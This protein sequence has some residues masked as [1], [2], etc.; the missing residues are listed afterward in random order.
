MIDEF[1]VL[2]NVSKRFV[3]VR[4]LDSVNVAIKRSEI[5]CLVGENGSGKSTLVKIISG[6][7]QPDEGEMIVRGEAVTFTHTIDSIRLGIEVIYQDMSLFPNLTVAENIVLSHRIERG[8]RIFRWN[9]VKEIAREA[10]EK[11]HVS[12][13]LDEVVGR[14]PV[15]SQQLVAICRALTSGVQLLVMDEATTALTKKEIDRLLSVIEDLRGKGL[16]VV[17]VSHKLNE[18]LQIADLVTILRDGRSVGTYVN[19]DLTDDK[20]TFLMTGRKLDKA[21]L[22]AKVQTS[23]A[24]LEATALTKSGQ[25]RN[26]SFSLRE[27]EIVG[28]TGLLGAGRTEL[29]LALFGLNPPDRGT[30]SVFHKPA[31]IRSVRDAV[32]LGIGYVPE[33]RMIQG[34]IMQQSVAHNLQMTT[35]ERLTGSMGLLSRASVKASCESGSRGSGSR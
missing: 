9:R 18:V 26:V 11:V 16:S 13:G 20:I 19:K 28:L 35:I 29:A 2:K 21:C 8:T 6:V 4:A 10:M 27:G 7:E 17:F 32:R 15:A 3:G 24:A 22:E 5:H 31:R 1:L 14:L 30:I 33:N 25:F 34:L 12:I 23:R